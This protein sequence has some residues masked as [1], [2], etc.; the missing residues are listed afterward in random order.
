MSRD[1]EISRRYL[2]ESETEENHLKRFTDF[3]Q[4]HPECRVLDFWEWDAQ[5]NPQRFV[6]QASL[7]FDE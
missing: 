1:S 6:A 4:N 2:E 5:H 3:F 7:N